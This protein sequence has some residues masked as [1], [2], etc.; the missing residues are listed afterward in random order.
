M[1]GLAEG[2]GG[3]MLS[4]TMVYLSAAGS[5]VLIVGMLLG[6]MWHERMRLNAHEAAWRVMAARNP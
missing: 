4:E 5:F 2:Q 1:Y 6:F 3:L